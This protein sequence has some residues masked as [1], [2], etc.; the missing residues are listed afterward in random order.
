MFHFSGYPVSLR[1]LNPLPGSTCAGWERDSWGYHGDDGHS[2]HSTGSGKPFGPTFITND[3]IG[4]GVNFRTNEIFFT[5][6]GVFIGK[7]TFT[8]SFDVK[9]TAH[10]FQAWHL[11]IP[12][13]Q[14]QVFILPWD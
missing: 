2:F 5:K 10:D 9:I 1:L 6:N 11:Q 13:F 8:Q 12:K 14:L 7:F 4:C 3:T